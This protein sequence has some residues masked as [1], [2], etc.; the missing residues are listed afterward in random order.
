M[1]LGELFSLFS[2]EIW[3]EG[4]GTSAHKPIILEQVEERTMKGE[5]GHVGN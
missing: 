4:Q 5:N 2:S 3:L 1:K